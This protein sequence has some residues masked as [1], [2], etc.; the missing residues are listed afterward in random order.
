[1]AEAKLWTAAFVAFLAWFAVTG[2]ALFR[3]WRLSSLFAKTLCWL[4]PVAGLVAIIA[5]LYEAFFGEAGGYRSIALGVASLLFYALAPI[6]LVGQA[7]C[8][9]I[10]TKADAP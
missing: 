1:M 8:L 6:L 7:V 5:L 9:F 3:S 4:V 2:L 10:A